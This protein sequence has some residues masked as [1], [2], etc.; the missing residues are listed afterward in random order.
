MITTKETD[1]LLDFVADM[2]EAFDEAKADDGKISKWE[3]AGAVKLFP[4]LVKAASG[5]DQ[6][7][8]EWRAMDQAKMDAMRDRFLG[9]RDWQPDTDTLCKFAV[10]FEVT[11]ALILG[12]IKWLNTVSPPTVEVVP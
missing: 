5:L 11:S 4:S 2:L 8:E 1:E 12:G 3:I 9:R 10:I 6:L 7:D